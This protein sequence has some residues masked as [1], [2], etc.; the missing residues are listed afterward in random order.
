MSVRHKIWNRI[1][2][3]SSGLIFIF[4]FCIGIQ[5]NA[6]VKLKLWFNPYRTSIISSYRK[7]VAEYKKLHPE[8]DIELNFMDDDEENINSI[9]T[10]IASGLGPDIISLDRLMVSE[11]ASKN[12]LVNFLDHDPKIT[13][14]S[15]DYIGSAFDEVKFKNGV[16]GLPTVTD[17]RALFYRKDILAE[18]GID[19]AVFEH[20]KGPIHL[21]Q[22]EKMVNK[23]DK[24]KSGK[25]E[26]IGFVP[27]FEQGWYYT[28]GFAYG[29]EFFDNN[30]KVITPDD[31]NVV[32]SFEYLSR[33]SKRLGFAKV[34]QAINSW[35]PPHA[36]PA[37][38]PFI[39]GKIPFVVNGSWFI[40]E[41]CENLNP[42]QWGV[43]YIPS[44]DGRKVSWSG[45]FA[46]VVNRFSQHQK[47]A[48]DFIK[49]AAG[50]IGQKIIIKKSSE[51]PTHL[52]VKV[53]TAFDKE[54]FNFLAQ[55]R[56]NSLAR[57][58]IPIGAKYWQSL[59]D[60][61]F[62]VLKGEESSEVAL[63]KIKTDIQPSLDALL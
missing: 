24:T 62:Q 19:P 49:F 37:D 12:I 48:I 53:D 61:M 23:L 13:K 32:K 33:S 28:W 40:E 45:G 31:P 43:T 20:H 21:S 15:T 44:V 57:P 34:D 25:F 11:A 42:N 2:N 29:G 38:H 30:N 3:T 39:I 9:V 26:R 51:L 60:S 8:I 22:F 7:I 47:E 4:L 54:R 55:I 5:A 27:W 41:L 36:P 17:V 1:Q 59:T 56:E 16:F 58:A 46:L 14:L 63:K 50:P 18:N 6:A 52:A 35:Y 10:S